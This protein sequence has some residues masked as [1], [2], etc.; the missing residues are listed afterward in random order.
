MFN[1]LTDDLPDE[2]G[3]GGKGIKDNVVILQSGIIE[4]R[5][6]RSYVMDSTTKQKNYYNIDNEF[7]F[8]D[9]NN[10]DSVKTRFYGY[11]IQDTGIYEEANLDE[12]AVAGLDGCGCYIYVKADDN[13]ITIQQDFNGSYGIYLYETGGGYFALSNSFYM[14]AEHIKEDHA[15]TLNKDYCNHILCD[16]L[17]SL[18]YQETP[19]CE[20]KLID[21]DLDMVIS[22]NTIQYRQRDYKENSIKLDSEE[23]IKVLDQW[24]YRWTTLFRNLKLHTNNISVDLSGGFDSRMTFMLMAESGIDLNE[25][26]VNSI[27]N[28]LKTHKEDYRIASEIAMHYGIELN[29]ELEQNRKLFYSLPDIINLSFYTK[30]AFHKEMYFK[31]SL[32]ENR[33]YKVTGGGGE[34]VRAHWN[35]TGS[36]FLNQNMRFANKYPSSKTEMEKSVCRIIESGYEYVKEKYTILEDE[37]KLY[38]LA[39]YREARCREHFGKSYVEDY[40][41]NSIVLSPLIDPLIRSLKLDEPDCKDDNLLFALIYTRYSPYFLTVGYEGGRSIERSTVEYAKMIHSNFAPY[42][43]EKGKPK[44][45]KVIVTDNHVMDEL[46]KGNNKYV[47]LKDVYQYVK[48]AFDSAYIKNLMNLY[49]NDDIYYFAQKHADTANYHPLRHCY[50]VLAIA[51][52]IREVEESKRKVS[53]IQNIDH[54]IKCQDYNEETREIDLRDH[55]YIKNLIT[56]RID[57]KNEACESNDIE[58][59]YIG[60]KVSISNPQWF[61]YNGKGYVVHSQKG[62]LDICFRCIGDGKLTIYLRAKDVRD[63]YGNRLPIFIHYKGF[64]LN[65]QEILSGSKEC[66]HDKPY[67]LEHRVKDGDSMMAHFEWEPSQHRCL[68]EKVEIKESVVEKMIGDATKYEELRLELQN[69]EKSYFQTEEQCKQLKKSV[70]YRLGYA[71]TNPVRVIRNAIKRR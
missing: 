19:V 15:L 6:K 57:I 65:G 38:P 50:A 1:H 4:V 43:K 21:K 20:I 11:S 52:V 34:A 40:F 25:I 70:S 13:E 63:K 62:S 66:S 35:V 59:L 24:F 28:E 45:F 68:E 69:K 36:D 44:D 46:A 41:S 2:G 27:N 17:A 53:I 49:F 32:K 12:Q 30:M 48:D 71:L 55:D 8:I 67:K 58:L 56:A 26:R 5:M 16:P 22:N 64:K 3:I 14:L 7:F 31:T 61:C 18:S 23:G 37:S 9:S 60:K 42:T 54:A 33:E 29:R 39:L 51:Q 10:L 47:E